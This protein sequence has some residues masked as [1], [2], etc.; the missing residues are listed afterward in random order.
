MAKKK[1]GLLRIVVLD[2]GW[3]FVGRVTAET[4][5]G[6]V[7]DDACCVRYWGTKNGLGELAASGPL[8]ETKLDPSPRIVAPMR[9]VIFFMD[10]DESKWKNYR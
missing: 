3:V 6:V 1:I 4:E 9:A 5:A 8:R 10:C 7:I 2:R